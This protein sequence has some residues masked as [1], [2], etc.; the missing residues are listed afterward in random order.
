MKEEVGCWEV[1]AKVK[2]LKAAGVKAGAKKT[3]VVPVKAVP[4]AKA[5]PP[6]KSVP[7]PSK[8]VP[9][10]PAPPVKATQKATEIDKTGTA[11]APKT[12]GTT[13]PT[14]KKTSTATSKNTTPKAS[15]VSLSKTKSL[16]ITL[17]QIPTLPMYETS[18]GLARAISRKVGFIEDQSGP[19]DLRIPPLVE[20][21]TTHYNHAIKSKPGA[22][23][24]YIELGALLERK[25]SIRAAADCCAAFPFRDFRSGG[26]TD[27]GQDDLY[28]YT[29]LGRCFMKEKRYKEVLLVDCL[30]AEG[31][32]MGMPCLG[33]YVEALDAAGES[34]LLMQVYAGVSK[35]PVDHPDLQAFFKSRYWT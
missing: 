13:K 23:D 10:K 9:S 1:A 31:R 17:K 33:K 8:P 19:K 29:E 18:I 14:S 32:A 24:A 22:H 15:N 21:I 28:L 26:G 5:V 6:A 12:Q 35:R 11:Q 7:P 30:V 34:K 4:V 2:D 27:P 16:S 25:V 3:A 20:T